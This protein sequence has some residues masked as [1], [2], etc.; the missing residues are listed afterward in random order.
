LG[1]TQ[2]D[3]QFPRLKQ[4]AFLNIKVLIYQRK[5]EIARGDV[6]RQPAKLMDL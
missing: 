2:T 5:G 3:S 4:A 6:Q 1:K